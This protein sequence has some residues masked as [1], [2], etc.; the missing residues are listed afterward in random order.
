MPD[1]LSR[2]VSP[3][4]ADDLRST[5][6]V[7]DDIPTFDGGTTVRDVSNELADHACTASCDHPAVHV[8]VTTRNQ[9]EARTRSRART[10]DEPRGDDEDPALQ[11]PNSFWEENDEFDA[12]DIQR[13]EDPEAGALDSPVAP[14]Q[15]DLP[16]PLTIEEIA[17]EQRVD[18]F[19]QT[20]LARQSE[21]RDS[22]FFEDHQG[23]LKRR[24]PF[25]PDIVQ[26]VVPRT[27]RARL[28]RLCHNPAIAGHPGQNRMYYA[29]RRE[30]YWPHL[31]ADV[32][33][34]TKTGK[35]FLLVITDRFSK[36]TQVVALR[37]ITAHTVAVAFCDSWVF[38]YGVPRTL[39]SDNGPQ[40][41]AK[42]FHSTCRV[43]GITNLYT[44]AYHPQTNG[45]V[46][47]Y[48]RTIASMLRNYVGEHQDDWDVY[49]GPL[50]YAY[51][52]HVHRTTRTTPFEL[53]LSRPPPEFS[54]RRAD[55]DAP[56]SNRGN[57]RAEFLK[58]LDSTIQ[59]AYGSL[60]RTQARYKRDFDK[61]IRRINSRLRPGEYVYLNPTDGA[62]TSNKLASPA[63]GPYRVLA[64]D[65]RIITIDR[66]GVTERVSA[67][68]CVYAP[69]P[70]DAPRA[71][72]TTPRDL[73]DKVT[74]G[75]QYAVERLLRH[76]VMEDGTT[77]FLIK[78][79]D[80]DAPTWTARTHVPEELVSRY[81]QRLRRRT[82]RDLT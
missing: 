38:K 74:A 70:I 39:L 57:Q 76:R 7:D 81:A 12:A 9:A 65:R 78:W 40:F 1:A 64:N 21:S 48:N 61:R 72:T 68:R 53:V 29:L 34:T 59:K 24:H 19:C 13:A 31:A 67:D 14:P 16:A 60:R 26:V 36:L 42:F 79:A 75:T 62:K 18:D 71:S 6:E 58:T 63:V 82:G 22:A 23:V 66:D 41:N 11:G 30:Y 25:D 5:V 37:T 27:L 54:L 10:R 35:W 51:N 43:L 77:E 15:D 69:P 50:T 33:A 52:S 32:A 3:K 20:V 28:L 4:V 47:R 73:A 45:Q 17:E 2:L 8:F 44:S 56:P 46:E 55:G 49:V 80:Y